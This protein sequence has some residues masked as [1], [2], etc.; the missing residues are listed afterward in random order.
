MTET[1]EKIRSKTDGRVLEEIRAVKREN[2][3]L[4]PLVELCIPKEQIE[5]IAPMH[6]MSGPGGARI[7]SFLGILKD[8]DK[9]EGAYSRREVDRVFTVPLR[10]FAEHAPRTSDGAMVVKTAEDFPYE[11]LPGGRNYPWHQIP[12]RFYFYETD[13]GVIWGITGELLYHCLRVLQGKGPDE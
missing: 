1:I 3:V 9:Y 10:W 11:L 5:L 13:G 7:S 4:I 2:A 12:R 8:Y 6:S